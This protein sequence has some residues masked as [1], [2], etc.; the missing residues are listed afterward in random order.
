MKK[1]YR[2]WNWVKF[3]VKFEH[4]IRN[5]FL[6]MSSSTSDFDNS[7]IFESNWSNCISVDMWW[8][9]DCS[10]VVGSECFCSLVHRW[11]EARMLFLEPC[12]VNE[13]RILVRVELFGQEQNGVWVMAISVPVFWMN[14]NFIS[15]IVKIPEIHIPKLE[16]A[17]SDLFW[18]SDEN[19]E[20][21]GI[22]WDFDFASETISSWTISAITNFPGVNN[23]KSSSLFTSL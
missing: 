21:T 6:M 8:F 2:N 22:F 13:F 4:E 16:M 15:A 1:I 11:L 18:K 20:F 10:V 17:M 3:S 7:S 12:P 14:E 19:R 9:L 5:L 23:F